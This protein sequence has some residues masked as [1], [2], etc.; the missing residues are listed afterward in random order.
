MEIF[1][2]VKRDLILKELIWFDDLLLL[3]DYGVIY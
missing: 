1:H 2:P 3:F